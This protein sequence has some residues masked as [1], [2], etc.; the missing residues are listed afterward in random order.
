MLTTIIA[1]TICLI[2]TLIERK[3][4]EGF[5]PSQQ[6]FLES[7]TLTFLTF[8]IAVCGK[9]NTNMATTGVHAVDKQE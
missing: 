2:K 9:Q 1:V 7:F 3:I 8:Q 4:Q 6:L 5:M